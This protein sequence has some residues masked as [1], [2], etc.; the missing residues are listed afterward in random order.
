MP[1]D[2]ADEITFCYA[3]TKYFKVEKHLGEGGFG[4][5][6]KVRVMKDIKDFR[7]NEV[8]SPCDPLARHCPPCILLYSFSRI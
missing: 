7:K 4:V 5:T 6:A 1:N 8:S 2:R 3:D